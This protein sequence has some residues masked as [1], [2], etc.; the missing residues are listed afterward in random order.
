[1]FFLIQKKQNATT[2][3]AD[4][5]RERLLAAG[6]QHL[7]TQELL[8]ILLRTGYKEKDVMALAQ[9]VLQS[10]SSL[11]ELKRANIEELQQIK[12]IGQ[13][14]A[15]EMKAAL[16]LGKRL[17]EAK[18]PKYGQV[19]SSQKIGEQLMIRL[20][21]LRQEHLIALYLNTKN[22]IIKQK[23]VFIGSLNQSIAHPRE[24][25]QEAVK[26]SA[27]RI[28]L[29]HNHPSG[30]PQPSKQDRLLTKRVQECGEIIGIDLLDHIIVG[31]E[32]YISFREENLL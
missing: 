20:K 7:S 28:V 13:V 1:M 21:D 16:E 29:A 12:G 10:F 15:I 30:N 25:Y 32:G 24:I 6:E 11:Y 22:D 3:E 4:R 17:C 27:A 9:D 5:P 2:F 23:T 31:H 19:L 18:E 8:A 14:K 26:C